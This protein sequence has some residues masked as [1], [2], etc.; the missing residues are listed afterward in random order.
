MKLSERVGGKM[1]DVIDPDGFVAGIAALIRSGKGVSFRRG[2]C[3]AFRS[4]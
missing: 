2:T 3:D 1:E 4:P